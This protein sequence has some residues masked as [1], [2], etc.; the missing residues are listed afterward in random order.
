MPKVLFLDTVHPNF[1][2]LL[3]KADFIVDEDYDSS[4]EAILSKISNYTGVVIRSRFKLDK[5]FLET[6]QNLKFIAR[7]GA[8]MENIDVSFAE[9]IGIK[10]LHAPEGNRTAVA[11]QAIAMLLGLMNNLFRA[12]NEV[13]S[14]LWKREEN[15]GYELEGKTLGIIGFGNMGSV[16]ARRLA[17]FDCEIL[18]YDKYKTNFGQGNIKECSLQ[19]I[20]ENADIVSLH[21]PLTPETKHFANA[22]FFQSFIKPIWFLNTARGQCLKTE[23]LVSAME[24]GLVR[25]AC[26]DVL[27]YE[28][29]SFESIGEGLTGGDLKT[30]NYLISSDKVVLS[31]HIAGW[32]FES[33]QKMAEVLVEK[34]LK[35]N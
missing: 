10:C 4:K 11:E 35:L 9:S 15:R 22:A 24:S 14:G 7:V 33:N 12:N 23:D 29:T 32:T 30:W 34:I 16:F 27:E 8:G 21:L 19:N 2:S 25:G 1:K 3:E 20:F 5:S 6:A 18:V 28:S 17:G 26:L 13:R 31:P